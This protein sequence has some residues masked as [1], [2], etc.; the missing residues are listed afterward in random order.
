MAMF[1]SKKPQPEGCGFIF[2][3]ADHLVGTTAVP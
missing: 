1:L 3:N 2:S